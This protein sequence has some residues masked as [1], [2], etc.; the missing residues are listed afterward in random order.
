MA[1]SA[2][3]L[4]IELGGCA[5]PVAWLYLRSGQSPPRS[6][7][8]TGFRVGPDI[9]DD[10]KMQVRSP[11]GIAVEAAVV[12]GV[13]PS[14]ASPRTVRTAALSGISFIPRFW[15][16]SRPASGMESTRGWYRGALYLIAARGSGHLAS[17]ARGAGEQLRVV[18]RQREEVWPGFDG[19]SAPTAA[20]RAQRASHRHTQGREPLDGRCRGLRVGS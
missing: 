9:A 15:L 6:S 5:R 2:T 16:R 8:R 19:M 13:L 4:A 17:G 20:I 3:R 18:P 12:E 1:R 14:D 10:V 11:S 7:S